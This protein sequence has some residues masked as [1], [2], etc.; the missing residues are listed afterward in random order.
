MKWINI[1]KKLPTEEDGMI[2]KCCDMKCAIIPV[3]VL[4]KDKKEYLNLGFFDLTKKYFFNFYTDTS[5]WYTRRRSLE[6]VIYW[7]S[8][9]DML[10]LE[11]DE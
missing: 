4:Q 5:D 11:K 1:I 10:A 6:N 2:T 3:V 8:R 9:K 7:I